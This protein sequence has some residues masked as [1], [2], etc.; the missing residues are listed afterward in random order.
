MIEMVEL[1]QSQEEL[2]DEAAIMDE[3]EICAQVLVRVLGL[4]LGL[5]LLRANHTEIQS[6]LLLN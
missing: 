6:Q 4:F 2:E 1:H 3:A 5:D